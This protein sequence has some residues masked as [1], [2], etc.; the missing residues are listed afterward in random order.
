MLVPPEAIFNPEP[1]LYPDPSGRAL[2]V[3]KFISKLKLWESDWAGER[4]RVHPFQQAI[5]RR[6]YGPNRENGLRQTKIAA[7]WLPRGNA[8]TT[9]A[10]AFG[11]AHFIGPEN[12]AGGQIITAAADRENAGIAFNMAHQITR[13]DDILARTIRPVES[14]KL[15]FHDKSNSMFKAI[16]TEAYSKH[17]MNVSFFLADEIHAWPPTEAK[18][19]WK[20]IT[21]SMVK[22]KQPLTIVISTAGEGQGF[23][24][25]WWRHSIRVATG[26]EED[27]TF[28]PIIFSSPEID[29][30]KSPNTW[31]F[32]NPALGAGFLNLDELK[33]KVN[34][35]QYFPTDAADF[36]RY[37]LNI[38][39]DGAAQPW[40]DMESVYDKAEPFAGRDALLGSRCYVGV[41]LASVNDL[42][43]VVALFPDDEDNNE[44]ERGYDVI[45]KFFI[46]KDGL[47]GK[48]ELDQAQYL[49]WIERGELEATE[50]NRI[51]QKRI[52]AYLEELARD[53][54]VVEVGVDRWNS[55][56]FIAELQE[57][58][59]EV[60]EFGQGFVSMATP[61]KELKSKI[62]GH[63]FRHGGNKALRSSFS[64]V[65]VEKDAAENEKFTKSKAR[66][67]I[68]GAV[69][70]A[71]AM[72][73]CLAHDIEE[74]SYS[75]MYSGKGLKSRQNAAKPK[76]DDGKSFSYEILQDM[77][78]PLFEEH[79]KRF[80]RWQ[81]RMD[82]FDY[83][84]FR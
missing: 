7:L 70:S 67:R 65:V 75:G 34:R 73:R 52:I 6:I 35:A 37:H 72:G 15:M 82:T 23:A 50:G 24:F 48:Q 83:E 8:K 47:R 45:A 12:E 13:Q 53:F 64:N 66:G 20:V 32:A 31:Y 74:E 25:E 27:P 57:R 80:E 56:A 62:L 39:Q 22:R 78:H 59:F 4:F 79:K 42:A 26:E 69:A 55:V 28:V 46:P 38:W 41:D 63:K 44:D 17:G 60:V 54:E 43:S 1:S 3:C 40:I 61:V 19:L 16:S 58:G 49:E 29:S 9:L 14:K 71:I 30:W 2:R 77:Q 18:K 33:E 11:L 5:I 76:G 84:E 68:D 51:D 21:D 81:E 10:A 36:R